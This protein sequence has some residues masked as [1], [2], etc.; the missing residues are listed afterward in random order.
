MT[1]RALPAHLEVLLTDEPVLDLYAHGP[2]RVPDGRYEEVVARAEQLNGDPRARELAFERPDFLREGA[3]AV[4]AE[5]VG[6]VDYL[7][8]IGA[9]NA[10]TRSDLVW[11]LLSPFAAEP[12]APERSPLPWRSSAVDYRPPGGDLVAAAGDDPQLRALAF[13]LHRECLDIFAGIAPLETR[14]QA[15][16]SLHDT[17]LGDPALLERALSLPVAKLPDLWASAAGDDVLAALPELA[18]PV[19]H[20]EWAVTGFLAANQHLSGYVP[21][22][23]AGW[24]LGTLLLHSSLT[25]VPAAF[26]MFGDTELYEVTQEVVRDAAAEFEPITWRGNVHGWLARCL[27]AGA[28]DGCR[29]WLDMAVRVTA[30]VQGLPHNPAFSTGCGVP[31][32]A[33]QHTLRQ[34]FRRTRVPNALVARLGRPGWAA[35]DAVTRP[36]ERLVGQ[37]EL[38]A[39][40]RAAVAD[41]GDRRGARLL[42]CGPEGTGRRTAASLFAHELSAT[43]VTWLHGELF[44]N[45]DD[46]GAVQQVAATMSSPVLVVDGL[47]RVLD[48]SCGATVAEEL[49]RHLRRRPGMHVIVVC[50]PGGDRRVFDANPALHQ[51]F[52]VAHTREFTEADLA[53]LFTRAVAERKGSVAPDV[54]A[55]AGVLLSRTPGIRNLRGARLA[56][57]LADQAVTAARARPTSSAHPGRSAHPTPSAHP[58]LS[59]AGTSA[60]PTPA[61]HPGTP[62]PSPGSMLVAGTD[63]NGWSAGAVDNSPP[64]VQVTAADLPARLATAPADPRAELDALAGLDTVKRELAFHVAEE[65]AARLRRAAGIATGAA[66][67]HFVFTGGAGTGKTTVARILGRLLAA[68]EALPAGQLVTVDAA[69]LVAGRTG[70]I[71][72]AVH[73]VVERAF[74]GVLCVEDAQALVTTSS[75][76]WRPREATSALLAA[77]QA[78]SAELVVVL[79]GTDAGVNELL[80][81]DPDL[82]A[83]FGQVLRFPNLT[84]EEFVG[85]FAAKAAAAGF[86]LTDGVVERVRQLLAATRQPGS[87]RAAVALLDRTIALQARRVLADGVVD[88]HESWHEILPADVP[89]T[90]TP[91][92][93]VE[94]PSD[95]L[96]EIDRLV[97]LAAVKQEV[98]LLVAEAKAERLR[99]DAG[100][101]LST[102]TR[103]LVFTGNPGTA[104]T[105]LAR[106]IAAAYAR[107]GLLSIGHL[108]EVT[109]TDLIG[110]YLGQTAPKVRAA[111]TR[112]L[113]GVLFIDEAYALTPATH[114]DD[115][116]REAL[117]ELLRGMEEHRDDL[118]VI[119]AG[120]SREMARFLQS[121]PGL[122]SRFPTTLEFPDYS[123]DELL[124]IFG[125]MATGAGYT[126]ADGVTSRVRTLLEATPRGHSFGN[127]RFVRNLL[128]RAV[129][130]QAERL[131]PTDSPADVRLLR[132]E[133]LPELVV[134]EEPEAEVGMGQY[135]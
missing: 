79:T 90:L 29:A 104:K 45:L 52:R 124:R 113:G 55:T 68:A 47:D 67:R 106:L 56:A 49:R 88:E 60:H 23:S 40:L 130:R 85:V 64:P 76:D 99:R 95:P 2:W 93:R 65:R 131:T 16:I 50:G 134:P 57:H 78:H 69:D 91:A 103:H 61:S 82:A 116:N 107:L 41:A 77:L 5:L 109:S 32:T 74:G 63:K 53:E 13:Q 75:D 19:A 36:T 25:E 27:V 54:A 4:A 33:F 123:D 89:Q 62:G 1:D 92:A 73:R 72:G 44:A 122:A 125:L 112:A 100:I 115:Y 6:L 132:P 121:N 14:R 26:A 30:A 21:G 94:L 37:P 86:A 35:P 83:H 119:V 135:L 114:W 15:M 105:T 70:E 127:G 128:D 7:P 97:G 129:A 108:V 87:G 110:E 34:Y 42:V 18:G 12:K 71:S 84:A 81:A 120:Y 24:A 9:V 17:V 31:V 117:A 11:E 28:A 101:P 51:V 118:V 58:G 39:A 10:G 102:P 46:S 48:Y 43:S 98:R 59:D 96:A 38:T 8:G 66:R 126:L 3:T 22:D 20:L 111:V 133:D 80:R